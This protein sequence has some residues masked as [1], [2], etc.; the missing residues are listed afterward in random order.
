MA[1]IPEFIYH[2]TS[3]DAFLKIV[4]STTLWAT[5]IRYLNDSAEF[6]YAVQLACEVLKEYAND[7]KYHTVKNIYEVLSTEPYSL[8]YASIYVVSFSGNGDLLS[9]WRAYCPLGSGF[10]I[11]FHGNT[12]E[13]IGSNSNFDLVPCEYDENKQ[14]Q[15]VRQLFQATFEQPGHGTALEF[16]AEQF[17]KIAPRLKHPTFQEEREWRLVSPLIS[18]EDPQVKYRSGKSMLIPYI[19]LQIAD[20][21]KRIII[22]HVTL[23]PTPHP[24]LAERSVYRYLRTLFQSG[25]LASTRDLRTGFAHESKIP[26]RAW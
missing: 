1:D 18:L 13:R 8:H 26:F 3:Q 9:Q 22:D 6:T 15:L 5:D 17:F 4:N 20:E 21:K 25:K 19:E 12:L 24:K 7:E 11:A 14:K 23:A 16:C 2:Y 10:S